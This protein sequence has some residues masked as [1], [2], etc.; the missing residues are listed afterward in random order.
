M[1]RTGH[2]NIL[3][4]LLARGA[5]NQF[6]NDGETDASLKRLSNGTLALDIS[7]IWPANVQLTPAFNALG[8]VAYGDVE[9]DGVLDRGQTAQRMSDAVPLERNAINDDK[10]RNA[11]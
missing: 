5:F 7:A 2:T 4:P 8:D 9:G 1:V 6:G 10:I 3:P 11:S